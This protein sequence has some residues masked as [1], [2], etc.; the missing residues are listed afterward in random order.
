MMPGITLNKLGRSDKDQSLSKTV[1][2]SITLTGTSYSTDLLIKWLVYGSIIRNVKIRLRSLSNNVRW[3][4]LQK[5]RLWSE[6]ALL[7]KTIAFYSTFISSNADICFR[8]EFWKTFIWSR[9]RKRNLS[10]I[11]REN[12]HF[13]VV[14]V[15]WRQRNFNKN[16]CRKLKP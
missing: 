4:R 11:K 10:S 5:R 16:A 15:R 12:G 14:I 3:L 13:H 7:L 2:F 1:I 9:K 6:F 8:D